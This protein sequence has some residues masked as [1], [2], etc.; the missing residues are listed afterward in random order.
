[1]V[2]SAVKALLSMNQRQT[3]FLHG[4]S[5]EVILDSLATCSM[6]R[7]CI[8]KELGGALE[9]SVEA[10]IKTRLAIEEGGGVDIQSN[11][12]SSDAANANSSQLGCGNTTQSANKKVE[13]KKKAKT[14]KFKVPGRGG[15][16]R[17]HK[18]VQ[19]R[20]QNPDLSLTN[21]LLA[22]GFIFEELGKPNVKASEAKDSD[23]VTLY[24]VS[25]HLLICHSFSFFLP[26]I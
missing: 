14:T 9:W 7:R 16:Q 6:P 18:A 22:G 26:C 1:V 11:H 3:V 21:A 23:G 2:A 8:P 13:G 19:A 20:V 24:Q 17:M 15:D 4:G 25:Y 10:F 12:L 5:E